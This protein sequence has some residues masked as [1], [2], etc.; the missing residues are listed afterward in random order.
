MSYQ[1]QFVQKSF[2][3]AKIVP[4]DDSEMVHFNE[5][6]RMFGEDGNMLAIGIKDS[7]IYEIKN[8][9]KLSYLT[10]ALEKINGVNYVTGLTNLQMFVKSNLEKNGNIEARFKLQRIFTDIP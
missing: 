8:F 1:M 9:R 3:L 7:S 4:D 10:S 2:N 5:F 6:K